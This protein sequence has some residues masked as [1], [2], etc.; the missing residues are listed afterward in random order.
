MGLV[1]N[2]YFSGHVCVVCDTNW[3]EGNRINR[4]F[5]YSAKSVAAIIFWPG[6]VHYKSQWLLK[7]NTHVATIDLW[8]FLFA[9][10]LLHASK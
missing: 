2:F 9:F 3:P 4:D 1:M 5:S 10:V 7:V 6:K 8:K